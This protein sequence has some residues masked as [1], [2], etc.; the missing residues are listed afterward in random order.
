MTEFEGLRRELGIEGKD[1]EKKRLRR[2]KRDRR[3]TLRMTRRVLRKLRDEVFHDAQVKAFDDDVLAICHRRSARGKRRDRWVLDIAV[4]PVLDRDERPTHVEALEC[5]REFE[6]NLPI[7][8]HGD[9]PRPSAAS[10][11]DRDSLVRTLKDLLYRY[12]PGR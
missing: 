6:G 3:H 5:W 4:R 12:P 10:Q 9:E 11:P 8:T 7:P 1:E 2:L